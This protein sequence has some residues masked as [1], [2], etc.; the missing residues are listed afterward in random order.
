[1]DPPN[2]DKPDKPPS[3]KPTVS[4][5]KKKHVPTSSK[6]VSHHSVEI[7]TSVEVHAEGSEAD[8]SSL[9]SSGTVQG[10]S[11]VIVHPSNPHSVAHNPYQSKPT[12]VRSATLAKVEPVDNPYVKKVVPHAHSATV[13]HGPSPT[14]PHQSEQ[15]A[16]TS[17]PTPTP[18]EHSLVAKIINIEQQAA[19]T[20]KSLHHRQSKVPIVHIAS[21]GE[22]QGTKS[23]IHNHVPVTIKSAPAQ[24]GSAKNNKKPV[25]VIEAPSEESG[26]EQDPSITELFR[27]NRALPSES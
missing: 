4:I 17:A 27:A 6:K 3:F 15:Q 8:F 20:R 1:M 16:T 19:A 12:G 13:P 22:L 21:M 23:L 14:V 25:Q 9:A 24:G 18:S 2:P 7:Q 10:S 26:T 11:H 5:L